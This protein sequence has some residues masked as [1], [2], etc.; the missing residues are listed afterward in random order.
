[1][2][3]GVDPVLSQKT[4]WSRR[5]GETLVLPL[6]LLLTALGFA[7]FA[8]MVLWLSQW[9]IPRLLGQPGESQARRNAALQ[10]AHRH[11]RRYLATLSRLRLVEFR[12]RGTPAATPC[13]VVANHPSLLDFIVL[14]RDFPLAVCLYKSQTLQ[15]PVLARFVQL[16]GYVE[17]MDGTLESSRRI[18][19]ECSQR[20]AEGHHVAIFPEGTR[21]V[22]ALE[23][24][25]F[26]TTGFHAA[27]AAG[28]P[29][30]PV[31]IHCRPL[32]LGKKQSWLAFSRRRNVMTIDYLPPIDPAEPSLRG[33]SAQGL[34]ELAQQRIGERL[35]QIEEQE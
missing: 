35:Q 21:S 33:R 10:V 26:R 13:V 17:G 30:Q 23:M 15:N 27:L 1:M 28:V 4:T 9:V 32:F 11:V 6:R 12:F 8:L 34:A 3:S 14:L 18:I 29:I 5:T 24:G 31:A 19:D 2:Q 22:G 16:A 20:L 25:R 7:Q